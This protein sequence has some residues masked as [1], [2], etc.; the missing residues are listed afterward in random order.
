M[1]RGVTASSLIHPWGGLF[2]LCWVACGPLLA[3]GP[4]DAFLGGPWEVLIKVGLDGDVLHFPLDVADQNNPSE[5]TQVLPVRGTPVQIRFTQYLPHLGWQTRAFP[6]AEGGCVARVVLKG[7]GL[8]QELWLD[9]R[10]ADRRSVSSAVGGIEVKELLNGN[11]REAVLH[12]LTDPEAIGVLSV[13]GPGETLPSEYVVHP[14]TAIALRSPPG[15]LSVLQYLPHYTV[16]KTTQQVANRSAD[17]LNPAVQVRL[18]L[19]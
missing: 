5:L 8:S 18:D 12:D 1:N 9:S 6:R 17:A 3:A 19:E 13:F 15:T 10:D 14:K 2:V 7:P 4:H 11:M 16:D